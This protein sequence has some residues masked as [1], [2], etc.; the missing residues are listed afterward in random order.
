MNVLVYAG[1]GTSKGSVDLTLKALRKLLNSSYDV[2]PVNSEVV[3]K[4]PWEGTTSLFVIPGGRDVPYVE[5]L[6]PDGTSKIKNWVQSGGN[7]LGI[8]AGAYFGSSRVEFERGRNEYEVIGS[9]PLA[10]LD[11]TAKGSCTPGFR[12]NDETSA[13]AVGVKVEGIAG[14]E[15][16]VFSV[17][18]NGGPFF[19]C[20]D[21]KADGLA[22]LARYTDGVVD[23]AV[24]KVAIVA[25]DFGQG[26][27]IL[28]GPHLETDAKDSVLSQQ[29]KK[30]LLES[31][32]KRET[33]M[34]SILQ[35]FGLRLNE[36]VVSEEYSPTP[37]FLCKDSQFNSVNLWLSECGFF[38]TQSIRIQDT[39]NSI[40]IHG[41]SVDTALL[42]LVEIPRPSWEFG[43]ALLYGEIVQSTHTLLEKNGKVFGNAPVD[44]DGKNIYRK[45]GGI[46]VTSSYESGF[47]HILIGC[48]INVANS[49]PTLSVNDLIRTHNST[50]NSSL[51]ELTLEEVLP[52]IL[53]T[54]EHLYTSFASDESDFPFGKFL[55]KYYE[56][57]IHSNQHVQL[58]G[59]GSA[60]IEGI[61]TSGLLKAVSDDGEV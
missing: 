47:F 38:G 59:K 39:V 46:L 19:E 35:K 41:E 24:G 53:T 44:E 45:L 58:E 8:C 1:A 54:F 23:N 18:A 52:R 11:G 6:S 28:C 22:I 55:P 10:F 42:G 27:V 36:T 3:S 50:T 37:M 49:R 56:Y 32:D 16:S 15:N 17:L 40:Q 5:S 34:K 31:N 20:K 9:R 60:V 57:W 21:E 30:Q 29:H 43:S 14:L 33:L 4:E 13:C 12:Y 26:K 7:Y 48:G 51:E 25:T 2:I 61:D